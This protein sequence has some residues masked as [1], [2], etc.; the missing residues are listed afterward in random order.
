VDAMVRSQRS[1]ELRTAAASPGRAV[2]DDR[3]R[4]EAEYVRV[5]PSPLVST[6]AEVRGAPTLVI[7]FLL[8]AARPQLEAPVAAIVGAAD[9]DGF[10]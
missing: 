3:A 4:V 6:L 1:A 9:V 7:G 5:V 10:R 2:V 8:D